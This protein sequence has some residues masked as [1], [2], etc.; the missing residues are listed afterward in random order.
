MIRGHQ[1]KSQLITFI[2]AS[3]WDFRGEVACHKL[4]QKAHPKAFQAH[5][6]DREGLVGRGPLKRPC[7]SEQG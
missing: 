1:S 4:M 6:K 7:D 5:K 3:H 2:I